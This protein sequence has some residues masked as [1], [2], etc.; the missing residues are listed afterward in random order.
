M[1]GLRKQTTITPKLA[2]ALAKVYGFEDWYGL[3]N[4]AKTQ[5]A[6]VEAVEVDFSDWKASVEFRLMSLEKELMGLRRN[7]NPRMKNA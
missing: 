5:E 2:T 1:E 3:V 4:D 6:E 7:L